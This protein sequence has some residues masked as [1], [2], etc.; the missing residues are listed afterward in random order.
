MQNTSKMAIPLKYSRRKILAI[1]RHNIRL[2]KLINNPK[3]LELDKFREI[4]LNM[5]PQYL[6]TEELEAIEALATT[7]SFC[8]IRDIKERVNE[9]K[10]FTNF[11]NFVNLK[12]N[13]HV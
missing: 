2:L 12:S 13:S 10:I 8:T 5:K 3:T 9:S 4:V 7:N 6:S 11:I 1:V